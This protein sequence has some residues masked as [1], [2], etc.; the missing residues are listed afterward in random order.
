[1]GID[2]EVSL[3]PPGTSSQS[4]I[5]INSGVGLCPGIDNR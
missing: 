1:M 5:N 3:V 2:P 4:G